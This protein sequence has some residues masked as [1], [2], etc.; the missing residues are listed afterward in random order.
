MKDYKLLIERAKAAQKNSYAP[1][2][3]FNVGAALLTKDGKIY[4]GCNIENA[5][6]GATICAER[7]AFGN[8]INDSGRDFEAI[9]IVGGKGLTS[10]CEAIPCGACLQ[11]MSEFCDGDFEIVLCEGEKIKVY[12]L[13]ELLPH[14]FNL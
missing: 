10:E 5:S 8:A 11:V 3:S 2:S 9:A 14:R 13:S 12:K 1:Y 4:T 6:Y 7:I